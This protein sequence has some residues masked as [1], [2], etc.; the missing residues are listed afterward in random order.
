MR[1]TQLAASHSRK[2]LFLF[3]FLIVVIAISP[4]A[5]FAQGEVSLWGS[6]T[7]SSGAAVA[8]A[9]VTVVNLETGRSR[10]LVTDEAGR[11]NAAALMRTDPRGG[12]DFRKPASLSSVRG[13]FGAS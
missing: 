9:E 11:F 8:G 2:L 6:V 3:F 4:G 12:A 10:A 5:A 7:D 13:C 1:F